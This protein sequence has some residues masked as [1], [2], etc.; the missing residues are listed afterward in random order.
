MEITSFASIHCFFSQVPITLRKKEMIQYSNL[1]AQ[2][3]HLQ[4]GHSLNLPKYTEKTIS[5]E[6]RDEHKGGEEEFL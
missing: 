6:R 4:D 5:E 2:T 1:T 3:C